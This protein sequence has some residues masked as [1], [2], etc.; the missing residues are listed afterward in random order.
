MQVVEADLSEALAK[1]Q[2]RWAR[3]GAKYQHEI[4]EVR[5]AP[6]MKSQIWPLVVQH[7]EPVVRDVGR[8]IWERASVWRFGW[9]SIYDRM[10]PNEQ[11]LTE[12]EWARFLRQDALPVLERHTDELVAVQEKVLANVLANEEVR[13]A[14]CDGLRAMA[15]DPELQQL[16]WDLIRELILENPRLHAILA[17]HWTGPEAQRALEITSERFEPAVLRISETLFGN[18]EAGITPELARVLR[19]KVLGK[20]RRWLFVEGVAPAPAATGSVRAPPAGL[21]LPLRLSGAASL[22]PFEVESETGHATAH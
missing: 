22:N 9:R 7:T 14:A 13:T 21:V 20:D 8:E 4:V 18:A 6:V 5:L 16:A 10:L 2:E 15:D 19:S 3:L 1:D 12:K 11:S 17:R